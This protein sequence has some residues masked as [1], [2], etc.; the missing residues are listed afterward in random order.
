MAKLAPHAIFN[1]ILRF[2]FRFAAQGIFPMK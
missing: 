2:L 1:Y